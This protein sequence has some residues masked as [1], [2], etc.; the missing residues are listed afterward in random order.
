MRYSEDFLLV[1]RS[2]YGHANDRSILYRFRAN[3]C[4]PI[5]FGL[6]AYLFPLPCN[7]Y[8]AKN[9]RGNS[10][11]CL[12]TAPLPWKPTQFER[13]TISPFMIG[14]LT[15]FADADAMSS[16]IS[17]SRSLLMPRSDLIPFSAVR[18]TSDLIPSSALTFASRSAWN[19]A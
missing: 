12:S 6:P 3:V 1:P 9:G 8:F 2:I 7:Q 13:S 18:L 15:L 10:C 17:A 4:D 19:L 16:S 14:P 5:F 11:S